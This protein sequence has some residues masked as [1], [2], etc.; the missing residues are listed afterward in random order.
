L[1]LPP[2]TDE[3]YFSLEGAIRGPFSHTSL[4]ELAKE[5]LI[6][7]DTPCST[8]PGGP[9]VP[10]RSSPFSAGLFETKPAQAFRF[11]R[12]KFEVVNQASGRKIELNDMIAAANRPRPREGDRPIA[13]RMDNPN[14]VQSMVRK[15]AEK[16]RSVEGPLT[17]EKRVD[18][19]TRDYLISATCV[20][21][22][23]A[24]VITLIERFQVGNPLM[25]YGLVGI[26]AFANIMLAYIFFGVMGR[27]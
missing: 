11:A 8:A 13:G 6:G 20:N 9:W 10:V 17:I 12:P 25:L 16:Q 4:A 18:S 7:P 21:V 5:G 23:G 27:S 2:T 19:R 22:F 24:G 15:V 26:L 3:I 1:Q 14:D